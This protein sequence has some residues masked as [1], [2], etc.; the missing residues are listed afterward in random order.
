MNMCQDVV[1]GFL[2]SNELWGI[3]IAKLL[4][5]CHQMEGCGPKSIWGSL[6]QGKNIYLNLHTDEDFIYSLMTTASAHALRDDI[7]W[8]RMDADVSNYF[9]F[10][11]QGIAMALRPRDMLIFNPKYQH[12]LSSCTSSYE[13]KDIFSLSLYLQTA[14]VGQNDNT[15]PLKE[16]DILLLG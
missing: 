7:D 14:I 12:C 10:A 13:N 4:G 9:V 16:T 5:E 11:E 2:P 15:L 1:N 8:Y 6:S 3:Q